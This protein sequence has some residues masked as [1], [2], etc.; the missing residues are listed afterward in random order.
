[1]HQRTS[2]LWKNTSKS[3]E[4]KLLARKPIM[5]VNLPS[6]PGNLLY[7]IY[8]RM[9]SLIIL[10]ESH[11]ISMHI[12]IIPQ[13]GMGGRKGAYIPHYPKHYDTGTNLSHNRDYM[14]SSNT[15]YLLYYVNTTKGHRL[16]T[17]QTCRQLH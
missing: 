11:I 7:N 9:L 1:M 17:C 15:H 12:L 3:F 8:I 2:L 5:W 6:L 10:V 14:L 16:H 4:R 13:E